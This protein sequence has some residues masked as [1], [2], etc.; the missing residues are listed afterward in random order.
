MKQRH[1]WLLA[2]LSIL[3]LLMTT[4]LATAGETTASGHVEVG[5][6]SM[7]V[8][9][10][11]A[12]VNEYVKTSSDSDNAVNPAIDLGVDFSEGGVAA[13]I[14]AD[15]M[16][17]DNYDFSA[18]ADINRVVRFSLGYQ[19]LQHWKDHETLSQMG[20]TARDDLGG[21]QPNVTTDKIYADLQAANGGNPVLV[22]GTGLA[23]GPGP[24]GNWNT[25]DDI[26]A[27]NPADA[28]DEE[29]SNDY[30]TTRREL[31][32]EMDIALPMLPNIVFHA[33]LRIETREGME[34]AIGLSK[35]GGCHVSAKGKDIDERTEEFTLG[36][37]GKFG[38][39]TVDYEYL[40]RDFDE[41]GATPSRWYVRPAPD[42]GGLV[43][44]SSLLY[45]TDDFE[46][47]RTPDSKKDSHHL[48]ARVD[49]T[50]STSITASYV[51]ADIES[52]K[53]DEAGIY[54]LDDKT[55]TSEYDGFNGKVATAFGPIRLS[56]SGGYYEIDGPEY[57]VTF[58][59]RDD[60]PTAGGRPQTHTMDNTDVFTSAESREVTE[61]GVDAVYRLTAGTTL[62]L[63]YEYENIDRD[64]A[65][66]G[67]TETHTLKAAVKSRL[68]NTLSGRVSYKYQNISDP[69]VAHDA[70]G[71][72]QGQPD[73]FTDPLGSGL[74]YLDAAQFQ[75][76]GANA[77]PGNDNWVY[78]WNS[79]YP[80]RGFDATNQPE[81]VHEIKLSTTWSPSP[82][83]AAT[84][85]L[86]TRYEEN[87]DVNYK[88]TTFVPGVSFW[89]APS[90]KVN[91][92]MSY[93]FNNQDT[94]NRACVGW[95]HG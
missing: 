71:I 8:D 9:D 55:L 72:A 65:E 46:F 44:A 66:L 32:S 5:L 40:T 21:A 29:V 30:L 67:E 57:S 91:L 75:A 54:E 11:P 73:A 94:E 16:G 24:D 59:K 50:S 39:V 27:Y 62:R 64:E 22:G 83:M 38:I 87:D 15:L 81:D 14:D 43:K 90:D 58:D 26:Q 69:F 19:S 2:L 76:G 17:S 85:F 88:Q 95:Y 70:T 79:V 1:Y 49:V 78:Y 48:K 18:K 7:D 63:G 4:T 10:N 52:T 41:Q 23:S 12:R 56:F 89:Y 25:A 92:T 47:A 33:G 34:Q 36:A 68:S 84:F 77:T 80:S 3:T 37:T 13:E 86:R 35:C 31:K 45:G 42:A 60:P 74:V 93:T 53:T 51:N 28:W 20:A 6:S 82:N 61:F